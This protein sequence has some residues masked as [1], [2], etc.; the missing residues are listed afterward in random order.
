MQNHHDFSAQELGIIEH[1]VRQTIGDLGKLNKV[2]KFGGGQSNPTYK[3]DFEEQ[4]CV[5]RAQPRG[6]LLKSA[7]QVDREFKVMKALEQTDVP[8]PKMYA[9]SPPDGPLGRGFFIMEYL[10]GTIYWDPALPEA[11]QDKDANALRAHIYDQ[12]NQVLVAL[13]QIE[14]EHIGLGTFGVPGNY[15]ERQFSRWLKQYRASQTGQF[16]TIELLI[17]WLEDHL[18]EDDSSQSLVHGDYRLDNIMFSK[19][20]PDQ[21]NPQILGVLDWEL[22][23]LGHPMADLS[24]QCMQWRLPHKGGFRGLQGIDRESLGIPT[25]AEY[26]AQYC[27]H[28]SIPAINNWHFYVA[29]SF[30][31]LMAILQ[32]VYK[33][34]LDGNASNPEIA[35]K[36]GAA[37]PVLADL[38]ANML[39]NET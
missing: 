4:S 16:D 29:F 10:D 25:E 15:F 20:A 5:L 32:G 3:L 37:I 22:S 6:K 2:T 30:F 36:Y 38:A 8:T 31:R 33:R 12:M 28:R 11:D 27:A 14:P 17:K 35:Q 26:V 21:P 24:Y 9:L 39:E 18:P 34:S 19:T 13:H 1:F 23:T 7:H